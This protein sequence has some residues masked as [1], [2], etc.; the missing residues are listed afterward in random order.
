MIFCRLIHALMIGRMNLS[1]R[2]PLS[3]SLALTDGETLDLK[4]RKKC[5]LYL[6]NLEYSSLPVATSLYF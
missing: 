3:H 2:I 5:F 1:K 4:H 6:I